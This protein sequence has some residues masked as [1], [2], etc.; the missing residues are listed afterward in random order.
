MINKLQS[1]LRLIIIL[2]L[3][4]VPFLTFEENE[5]SP[6]ELPKLIFL[7]YLTVFVA[8]CYLVI[9]LKD[10]EWK[11]RWSHGLNNLTLILIATI[12]SYQVSNNSFNSLW[13]NNNVPTDSVWTVSIFLGF[14]FLVFQLFD[15]RERI[16]KLEM[17]ILFSIFALALY[18]IVQ[19]FGM[20]PID[21][22]GYPEM[23]TAA[24]GTIGQSVGYSTIVGA[25][26]PLAGFIFLKQKEKL[27][28]ALSLTVLTTLLLG[29]MYSGSRTPVALAV[30][31][32]TAMALILFFKDRSIKKNLIIYLITLVTV[33]VVYFAEGGTAIEKKMRAVSLNSGIN[34]R[35]Q[36]W[37][38]GVK[39]WQKY[40]ILGAGP[41]TFA[42]ELKLANS[43]DFNTNSKWALYWHKA[44]NFFFHYLATLGL[45]GLAAHLLLLFSALYWV[46]CECRKQPEKDKPN[47]KSDKKSEIDQYRGLAYLAIPI[48][49]Y[50][51]NLTAFH[52]VLTQL[53]TALFFVLYFGLKKNEDNFNLSVKFPKYFNYFNMVLMTVILL[54]VSHEVWKF[55]MGDRYFSV[56]RR[57]FEAERNIPKALEYI[58]KAIVV[59]HTDCRFYNRKATYLA[60]IYKYEFKARPN[61][62]ADEAVTILDTMTQA[63]VDCDPHGP[64]TWFFRGKIFTDI[65]ME[66]MTRD[67]NIAEQSFLQGAKYAPIN[68]IY[69][70]SL[71]VVYGNSGR[72]NDFLKQ[73]YEAIDLKKDYFIAYTPLIEYLYK[74]KNYDEVERLVR[75]IEEVEVTTPDLVGELLK[76]TEVSKKYNDLVRAS[77]LSQA[78]R[79]LYLAL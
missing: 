38:D 69:K 71:G 79:R 10:R 72:T 52:F 4:V 14:S 34:E 65:Y 41:E 64:E 59:K 35:V 18:G 1:A 53:F 73:M 19:H 39:I 9:A 61:F 51:A 66:G 62:N 22:W 50:L 24:Y 17:S 20:D 47:K 57:Y 13:G 70:F 46:W 49:I 55:W 3:V 16:L 58:D 78:H 11:F 5:Q 31:I 28:I 33:Q 76:T 75:M 67:L 21:W 54:L 77:R 74:N 2:A 44:H 12:L 56:S 36:V 27:K 60:A 42:L 32:T 26:I 8:I 40:P 68:P 25:F 23:R 43:K 63:A 29:Q 30:L 48:F 6:F 15:T 37:T 45:V 7:T